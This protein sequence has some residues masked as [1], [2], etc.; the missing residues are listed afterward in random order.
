MA[1]SA[2][3]QTSTHAKSSIHKMLFY[4]NKHLLLLY[5]IWYQEM[6]SYVNEETITLDRLFIPQFDANHKYES[7]AALVRY[8]FIVL[9]SDV[10]R[11]SMFKAAVYVEVY[12][13]I[14]S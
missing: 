14:Y 2:V 6:Q 11:C 1:S 13:Q 9:G 12:L 4:D 8:T 10:V 7:L 3:E 5:S